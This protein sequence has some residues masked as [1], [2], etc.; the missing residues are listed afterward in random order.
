MTEW[1]QLIVGGSIS[2][3]GPIDPRHHLAVFAL[4]LA[5]LPVDQQAQVEEE[6][7]ADDP[8]WELIRRLVEYKKFK[9]AAAQ[10]QILELRQENVFPR[11]PPKPEF[12]AE[13]AHGAEASIFD[14]V[15]AVTAILQ[16][17]T[18]REDQRDIFEDR[19]SVSEKIEHLI[20]NGVEI[21]AC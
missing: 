15:N 7:E 2:P 21:T 19:F 20:K 6:E 4:G 10:F 17:V 5:P 14:L 18:K 12:E 16:R 11:T 9:D 3:S 8:R 13:A 1:D